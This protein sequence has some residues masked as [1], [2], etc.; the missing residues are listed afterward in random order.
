MIQWKYLMQ[1]SSGTSNFRALIS[2]D[3]LLRWEYVEK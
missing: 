1:F 3:F 2:E